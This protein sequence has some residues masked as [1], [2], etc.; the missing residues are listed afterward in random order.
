M[1]STRQ[2][3]L[4]ANGA[5]DCCP[6]ID[7]TL[8]FYTDARDARAALEQ[9]RE[10]VPAQ[11][12]SVK[13]EIVP[14]VMEPGYRVR[15]PDESVEMSTSGYVVQRSGHVEMTTDLTVFEVFLAGQ[16]RGVGTDGDICIKICVFIT[17]RV[18]CRIYGTRP[19]FKV[20]KL[21]L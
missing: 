15:R 19:I 2:Q 3:R 4:L 1:P 6:S 16:R 20:I 14:L 11:A 9:V 8:T 5:H 7:G 12:S 17:S 10:R 18:A 13:L 21:F